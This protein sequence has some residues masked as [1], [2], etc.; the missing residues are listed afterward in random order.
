MTHQR[1]ALITSCPICDNADATSVVEFPELLFVRCAHC[2]LIYKREQSSDLAV[3]YDDSYFEQDHSYLRRWHHRV[4]KC[5]RQLLAALEFAPHA[6]SVLDVGCAAG[7]VL[8]AARQLELDACGVDISRYAVDLCRQRGYAAEPGSLT[9]LPFSNASFDIVTAKHTLEHLHNP[10]AGLAEIRRVLRRGG[11][12]LIIV[13]DAD[14]WKRFI[15]PRRGSYFRPDRA[16]REH[17]VYFS[18]THLAAACRRAALLPRRAGKAIVRRR[19]ARSLG[20]LW[21]PVRFA[22]LWLWS[23]LARLLHLRR[24][25]QLIAEAQP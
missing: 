4:R 5:R 9:A 16:G 2:G 18:D 11:V 20:A 1:Q 15:L 10:Q 3:P 8:E 17:H 25:I 24:E 22:A 21:E 14:Y 6:R 23:T 7:Y 19:L 12:A 13:P